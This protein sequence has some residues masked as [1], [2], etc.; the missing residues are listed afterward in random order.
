LTTGLESARTGAVQLSDG[1]QA[2]QNGSD[3][4]AAGLAAAVSA[5]GDLAGSTAQLA[6][7]LE[8]L[9]ASHPELASDP[10]A[11]RLAAAGK[12]VAGGAKE[13]EAGQKKLLAGAD[14]LQAGNR[15]LA[16]GASRLS[17]GQQSML[18]GVS[19]LQTGQGQ[20][21]GGLRQWSDKF[22]GLVSG[23]QRLSQGAGEV[24][25][26]AGQLETGLGKLAGGTSQ[27]ADGAAK[28]KSGS[29]PLTQGTAKLTDGAA[30]L[31]GKLQN[32]AAE[33]SAIKADDQVVRMLAEPVTIK[34]NDDRK[35]QLY[36][37]GIAPYFIS[38]ALFAGALVFT[39]IYSARS[40]SA[41]G[42]SGF[43][44]FVSKTL[45]FGLM[46][47]AQSLIAS[48]LLLV[49]IGLQVQ[50][51]PLFYLFMALTSWTFMFIV[52][53]LVTWLDQIGRFLVLLLMI[54]QLVSSAGT[55]PYELLPGWAQAL[56]PWLP[57]TYSIRGFR[58]VISSGDFANLGAQ[59]AVL[60]VFLVAGLGL[61][62]AYFLKR[63]GKPEEEQ[64]IP[65]RI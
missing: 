13:M 26:G 4:L 31:A 63:K 3:Q 17:E 29:G 2:A 21:A 58:D 20:V 48:T 24:S 22:A 23:A 60:A 37:S 12:A 6:G 8:Q 39:T 49:V 59:A 47:F 54:F 30:T 51:V 1:L 41:A 10:E 42:A 7:G 61:T 11:K 27:V 65:V 19:R 52:Q 57:M 32:A 50:S 35:V 14:S 53:A 38:M 18:Q 40:T 34:A 9:M 55:F 46:S 62:L 44:L 5:A 45:T 56:N 25:R 43:R 64:L 15:K 28:L 33:T 16:G 36:G